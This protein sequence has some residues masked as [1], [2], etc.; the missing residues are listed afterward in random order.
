M[1]PPSKNVIRKVSFTDEMLKKLHTLT[2]L[3]EKAPTSLDSLE[4]LGLYGGI[5]I[6]FQ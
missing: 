4:S 2:V 1:L 6:S 3:T 5:F